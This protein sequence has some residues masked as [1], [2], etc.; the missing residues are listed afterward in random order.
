VSEV[1]IEGI[2][3]LY[4]KLSSSGVM[5]DPIK[6]GALASFYAKAKMLNDPNVCSCKKGKK[7]QEETLRVYMSLPVQLRNE[8]F[9][10]TTKQVLGESVIIFKANGVEF[11]RLT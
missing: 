6:H 7:V 10:T 1:V 11:S 4:R 3:D 8:P 2:D 9:L 5:L